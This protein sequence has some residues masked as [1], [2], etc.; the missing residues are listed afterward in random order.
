[1]GTNWL[2]FRRPVAIVD[3]V[4][5]GHKLVGAPRPFNDMGFFPRRVSRL[6]RYDSV[7]PPTPMVASSS[8]FCREWRRRVGRSTPPPNAVGIFALKEEEE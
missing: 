5:P 2:R 8:P 6:V 1:V 3:R 7:L 4:G